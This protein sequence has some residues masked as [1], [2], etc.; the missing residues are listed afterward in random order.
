M[1]GV[2]GF[3]VELSNGVLA[4][5]PLRLGRTLFACSIHK[6][7][8]WIFLL[9]LLNYSTLPFLPTGDRRSKL[10]W[11]F[12]KERKEYISIFWRS[13]CDECNKERELEEKMQSR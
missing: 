7:S 3:S 2:E 12:E 11:R 9:L 8:S 13:D 6:N 1:I 5:V 4:R 10:L